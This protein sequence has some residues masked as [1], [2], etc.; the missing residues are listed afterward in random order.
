MTNLAAGKER[1]HDPY[2]HAAGLIEDDLEDIRVFSQLCSKQVMLANIS[3]DKLLRLYQNDMILLTNLF[4]MARREPQLQP[5]FFV[6]YYGWLGELKITRAKDG[7]ERWAQANVA[8]TSIQPKGQIQGYGSDQ[9][10]QGQGQQ[11]STNVIQKLFQR[12]KG[13]GRNMGK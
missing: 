2:G 4:D 7:F 5:F 11:E 13:A 3:D 8:A 10:Q 1:P 12:A 6:T 9:Q